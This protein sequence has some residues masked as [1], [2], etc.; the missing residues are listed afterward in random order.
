M[1]DFQGRNEIYFFVS[2]PIILHKI[3]TPDPKNVAKSD[4]RSQQNFLIQNQ[5]LLIL[6][7]WPVIPDPGAVIPE[8]EPAVIPD[9]GAVILIP[10]TWLRPCDFGLAARWLS[11]WFEP[12]FLFNRAIFTTPHFLNQSEVKPK[13]IRLVRARLAYRLHVF[14]SNFDF[15]A[16]AVKISLPSMFL[17][18]LV[19]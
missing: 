13:P 12:S 17:L 7:P 15:V 3:L 8:P 1:I 10:Y 2:D 14:A 4:P 6:I 16:H 11:R 18:W 5:G 9:P 19:P